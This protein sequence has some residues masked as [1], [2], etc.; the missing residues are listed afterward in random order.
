L[1]P[2]FI[3]EAP[4]RGLTF[5]EWLERV[6]VACHHADLTHLVYMH[7]LFVQLLPFLVVPVFVL[8]DSI[9]FVEIAVSFV[10]EWVLLRETLS[11]LW[12]LIA[13]ADVSRRHL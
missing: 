1:S 2:P 6:D 9:K 12:R 5:L 8:L 7:Q 11:G 13:Q 4:L 3:D 10:A